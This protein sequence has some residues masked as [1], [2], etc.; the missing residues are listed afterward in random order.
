MPTEDLFL[1]QSEVDVGGVAMPA[2]AGPERLVHACL[3]A[4][5][6][7]WNYLRASRDI[8]Q[9][10]LVSEVDWRAAVHLAARWRVLP[11]LA[12]GITTTWQLLGLDRAHPAH[13]WATSI[14][15]SPVD[16]LVLKVFADERPF[17]CQAL[18]AVPDLLGRG[19]TEYLWQLAVKP[20]R[21]HPD[22][23]H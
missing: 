2:L 8:G 12:R 16:R 22:H 11:P 5:I 18:T 4:T 19:A 15:L 21:R 6:G 9:L 14:R 3:H 7:G 1:S 17:S 10:I 20:G 23:P 13:R